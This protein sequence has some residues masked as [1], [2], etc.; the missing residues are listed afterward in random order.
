M[1]KKKEKI[2]T[3][4]GSEIITNASGKLNRSQGPIKSGTGYHKSQ[5][6]YNRKG[7][8]TQQLRNYLKDYSSGAAV[9]LLAFR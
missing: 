4:K 3:I 2:A 1:S 7:K 6:D 8:K 9:C 5:K